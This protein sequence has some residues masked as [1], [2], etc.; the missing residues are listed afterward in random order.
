MSNKK[1]IG[2]LLILFIIFPMVYS[3]AFA[4][5]N[6]QNRLSLKDLK[7][8]RV[9]VL[10]LTEDI[11]NLGLT[12]EVIQ[13][14]VELKL[15]MVGINVASNAEELYKIPGTPQL[16][17]CITGYTVMEKTDTR[18]K[19]VAYHVSISVLQST[20]LDRNP[21][22]RVLAVT[23]EFAMIGLA[24]TDQGL[25]SQIRNSVKDRADNFINAYLSV[26]PKVGK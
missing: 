11:K 23:W 21:K 7:G 19:G 13:T 6:E 22:L 15:R 10:F 4:M 20:F 18:D 25:V 5:D 2:I 9:I 24:Y 16:L 3:S 17:V 26:N 14:D 12:E 8:V 1:S